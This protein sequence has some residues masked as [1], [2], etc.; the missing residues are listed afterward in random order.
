M[1]L[2]PL[3]KLLFIYNDLA[4]AIRLM[5]VVAAHEKVVLLFGGTAHFTRVFELDFP[6]LIGVK[7][8][9]KE[10]VASPWLLL[11]SIFFRRRHYALNTQNVHWLMLRLFFYSRNL[12]KNHLGQLLV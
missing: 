8:P 1:L 3:W 6:A 10:F 9:V 2:Y 11:F 12:L 5:T 7:T 4:H